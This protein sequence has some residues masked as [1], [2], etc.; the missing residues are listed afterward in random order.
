MT[1]TFTKNQVADLKRLNRLQEIDPADLVLDLSSRLKKLEREPGPKGEQGIP[2]ESIVGPMGL[3]G[4]P[5]ESIVGPPGPA[6]RDGKD[7][8]DGLDGKDGE[9]GPAG[10]GKQGPPGES[11]VGQ[12]GPRGE[13][14][15]DGKTGP[16]GP[17]PKHEIKG[18]RIRFETPDGWGPWIETQGRQGLGG[19]NGAAGAAGVAGQ[20]AYDI[21][22]ESGFVGTKAEWL[23]SLKGA[24]LVEVD[25]EVQVDEASSSVTYVGKALPGSTTS[26]AVWQIKRVQIT[27]TTTAIEYAGGTAAFLSVWDNRAGLSYS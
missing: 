20:S 8:R 11:I 1:A 18:T 7:G 5:G 4:E 14:G 24:D 2:G 16:V 3:K 19:F 15:A 12:M 13:R 23:E 26:Q 22:V 6:G 21:A 10:E 17:M 27:G 9:R 25:Y